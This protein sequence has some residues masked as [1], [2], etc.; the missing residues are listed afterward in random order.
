MSVPYALRWAMAALPQSHAP[1][2]KASTILATCWPWPATEPQDDQSLALTGAILGVP[3]LTM[4]AWGG[5]THLQSKR[6]AASFE[7]EGARLR[8]PPPDRP[9]LPAPTWDDPPPQALSND[10]D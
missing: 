1:T 4:L 10:S 6:A 7:N 3:G 9:Y 5:V 8:T 2:S